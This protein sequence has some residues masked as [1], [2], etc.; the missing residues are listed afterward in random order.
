MQPQ[1]TGHD[2]LRDKA[3]CSHTEFSFENL[4]RQCRH[5]TSKTLTQ[6]DKRRGQFS[7]GKK[8]FYYSI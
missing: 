1:A 3:A 8:K 4:M 5:E 6:K 7:N 2:T